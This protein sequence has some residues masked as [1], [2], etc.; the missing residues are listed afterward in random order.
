M[1]SSLRKRLRWPKA[2]LLPLA[3][4]YA[5]SALALVSM[6]A[7]ESVGARA[8]CIFV[9]GMAVYGERKPGLG[10]QARLEK[11]LELWQEKRAPLIVVSGGGKGDFNESE[12][13]VEWLREHGVPNDAIIA[14]SRSRSTREN[15]I[16]SAPLMHQRG[17]K[18]ALIVSQNMHLPRVKV[19][20]HD[21][22]IE[23][24]NAPC[25]G[26]PSLD[27]IVPLAREAVLMPLHA[28]GVD[29]AFR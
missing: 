16:Y 19:C 18:R 26:S 27:V 29:R 10:L 25:K 3:L 14:E 9:P 17:I 21:E 6:G 5:A 24:I 23:T 22:G 13:M 28:L 7:D 11:A 4:C 2:V 12:V 1:A 15:A 8:D 20:L